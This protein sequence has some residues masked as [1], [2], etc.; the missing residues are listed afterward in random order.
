M[1][2]EDVRTAGGPLVLATRED[3]EGLES[4]LWITFPEGYREYLTRL[5]EGILGS[6]VRIY[7]PWRVENELAEWRRRIAKYWFWDDGRDVLPK[8]RALECI[9]IGDT[10]N[11]DEIVFHP[12]RRNRLFVLPRDEELI[13]EAGPDLLAAV[14]WIAQSGELVEPLADLDFEP[15]DSR[16][17]EEDGEGESA[18]AKVEDPEG[19]SLD[20]LVD[21]GKRWAE[22]HAVRLL[23]D[24]DLL[25][26][27]TAD[28]TSTL[29]HEA[30][31]FRGQ[32]SLE[33]G[34]LAVFQITDQASRLE[35]GIF[36]WSNN[37]GS[38]SY[39]L[40]PNHANLAKL[41]KLKEPTA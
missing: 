9:I 31:K 37:E 8:E 21:L 12:T 15:I 38:R 40:A 1:N 10:L 19:E 13:F 32:T 23:A 2:I 17:R 26:Q 41:A 11:G 3:I 30:I 33:P 14:D 34:Y 7:P 22:R 29:L 39:Q 6:F 35:V 4:R 28:Q 16:Q 27:M 24:E 20:D 18:P 25:Q 5:G 36:T